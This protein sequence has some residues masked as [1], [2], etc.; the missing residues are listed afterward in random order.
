MRRH[1]PQACRPA[2]LL[3]WWP[4]TTVSVL[5]EENVQTQARH[6]GQHLHVL[7]A[8]ADRSV[9]PRPQLLCQVTWQ[10]HV[11]DADA[12]V[13]LHVCILLR[14][15][16]TV[17]LFQ[18]RTVF[19][20]VLSSW[21]LKMSWSS[22][23]SLCQKGYIRVYY[24]RLYYIL[25]A[26]VCSLTRYLMWLAVY[27]S[28]IWAGS[29]TQCILQAGNM[30]LRSNHAVSMFDQA[31]AI[32]KIDDQ[33]N[34]KNMQAPNVQQVDFFIR[35]CQRHWSAYNHIGAIVAHNATVPSSWRIYSV[36]KQI[37]LSRA[38]AQVG[39]MPSPAGIAK[40]RTVV[41]YAAVCRNNKY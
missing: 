29:A 3:G 38:K 14:V 15:L 33:G 4:C 35:V 27:T 30:Y 7:M 22:S 17:P 8:R 28:G 2:A 40:T 41:P 10:T 19:W 37:I 34:V 25:E 6:R 13:W 36:C 1:V 5:P 24:V 21:W 32:F 23:N 39:M 18:A 12:E 26:T 31:H 11:G 9:S 20:G 16:T